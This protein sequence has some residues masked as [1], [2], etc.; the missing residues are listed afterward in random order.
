[1]FFPSELS[2]S[3]NLNISVFKSAQNTLAQPKESAYIYLCWRSGRSRI[4]EIH[5]QKHFCLFKIQ[6]NILILDHF[7]EKR[8]GRKKEG[9]KRCDTK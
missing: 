4:H 7:E 6:E 2:M 8:D 9:R 5:S 1:M 3:R